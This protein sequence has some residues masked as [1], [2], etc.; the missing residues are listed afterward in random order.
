MPHGF[1]TVVGERLIECE[2][3]PPVILHAEHR[4]I[5]LLHLIIK[6]LGNLPT[7]FSG[8]PVAG[9]YEHEL[10]LCLDHPMEAG[11]FRAGSVEEAVWG[12]ALDSRGLVGNPRDLFAFRLKEC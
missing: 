10:T 3:A 7:S 12:D 1:D 8:R 6:R 2:V 5:A 11:H 4:P 9:P